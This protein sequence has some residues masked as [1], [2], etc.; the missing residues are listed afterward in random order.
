MYTS[1]FLAKVLGLYFIITS[2]FTFIRHKEVPEIIRAMTA[3]RGTLFLVAILTLIMGILLVVSHNLWVNDWRVVIT[4]VSWLIFLGGIYRLF[5]L[6]HIARV[7]RW[8]VN[9]RSSAIIVSIIFFLI[10]IFFSYK[11]FF[12]L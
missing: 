11:G 6:D 8:W 9:H 4:L 3:E 5:F 1:I 7:G 10:G 12:G 2:L